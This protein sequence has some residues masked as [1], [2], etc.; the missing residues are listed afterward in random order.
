MGKMISTI[1]INIVLLFCFATSGLAQTKS[2][3]G[4]VRDE[5][6]S[7]LPGAT[8]TVKGSKIATTTDVNGKFLFSIPAS[9]KSV[10]ISFVGMADQEIA[11][12][13]KSSFDVILKLSSAALGDVVV[14]GYGTQRRQDVNGAISSVS[15]KEIANIPQS[16]VDQLLQGK[17]AGVTVTQNNGAPGAA[18]SVRVRGIT[19]FAGSEPLYVVNGVAI[20][21][22][23]RNGHQLTNPASPSEQESSPSVLSSLN[24]NDIESI[25]I[26][27]DA[28]ATAIYGSRGSN[29]VVIITTKKGKLG[30]S[31]INFDGYYGSQ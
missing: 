26:L 15:A 9:S 30:Q 1:T 10:V 3:N 17:A 29:G 28:S 2:I 31:K 27:K 11:I 12:G 14:I 20:D 16:S 18:V 22:N 4:T 23:A 21:G 8:I 13:S 6:G 24:P 7:G 5:K 25:D 19:T